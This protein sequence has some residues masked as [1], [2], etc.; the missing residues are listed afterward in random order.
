MLVPVNPMNDLHTNGCTLSSKAD[1]AADISVHVCD[2]D[3]ARCLLYGGQ[4]SFFARAVTPQRQE[5][6]QRNATLHN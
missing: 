5:R 1:A 2:S 3:G 4:H 6:L